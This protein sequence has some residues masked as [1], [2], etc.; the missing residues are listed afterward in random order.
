MEITAKDLENGSPAYAMRHGVTPEDVDKANF[1]RGRIENGRN[2]ETPMPGDTVVMIGPKRTY[3]NGY[4]QGRD[5]ASYGSMC[6]CPQKPFVSLCDLDG[7]HFGASGGYWISLE[8]GETLE[9]AGTGERSFVAW[10]HDGPCADGAFSFTATVNV[11]KM[12][13]GRI[14]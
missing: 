14:Y 2:R 5:P 1:L 12:R 3:R 9:Y 8:D 7:P 4:L 13:S 6:A 10:G 11:W